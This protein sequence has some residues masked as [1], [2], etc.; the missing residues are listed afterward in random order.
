MRESISMSFWNNPANDSIKTLLVIIGVGCAAAFVFAFAHINPFRN[1]GSVIDGYGYGYGT[2]LGPVIETLPADTITATSANLNGEVV[3]LNGTFVRSGFLLGTTTAYTTGEVLFPSEIVLPGTSF[4]ANSSSC[5]PSGSGTGCAGLALACNTLY[6]VLAFGWN[7]YSTS[8]GTDM[9]FTTASCTPPPLAVITVSAT[10][11]YFTGTTIYGGT[12]LR[13]TL[14]STGPATGS[15]SVGFDYGLTTT[16]GHS[17]SESPLSV[18][19]NFG[20]SVGLTCNTS[21]HFR[22]KA[23]NSTGTAYGVDMPF[24]TGSCTV[25]LVVTNAATAITNSSATLN[26]SITSSGGTNVTTRGFNYGI[27][28]SYGSTTTESGSWT[29]GTYMNASVSGLL[30]NTLYHYDAYAGNAVGMVHGADMTFTTAPCVVAP[31]VST[32]AATIVLAVGATFNGTLA[33]LGGATS[34]AVGFKYGTTTSFGLTTVPAT[35]T[36]TGAFSKPVP[37]L[38]CNTTYYYQSTAANTAG[39][40][41]GATQSFKTLACSIAPGGGG[42]TTA[43]SNSATMIR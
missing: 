16:Y 24:T 43:S 31:T 21:Y 18:P 32:T 5:I 14:V 28:T 35:M 36:A 27:T 2:H 15:T 30:C 40:A 13:G 10:D 1:T 41:T 3:N 29:G 19:G 11:N 7:T 4:S 17:M 38:S 25:P 20:G 12:T 39:N 33:S 8:Y 23:A 37:G 22:A 9:T 34:A 42:A 26:G 6:H